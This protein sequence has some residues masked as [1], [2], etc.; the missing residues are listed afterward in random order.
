[1]LNSLI[2]SSVIICWNDGQKNAF[3][4]FAL[5]CP[6]KSDGIRS[7]FVIIVKVYWEIYG[8]NRKGSG[9]IEPENGDYA[10]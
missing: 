6:I 8:K 7:L 5:F 10:H 2:R 9:D 4:P 3:S 1:M